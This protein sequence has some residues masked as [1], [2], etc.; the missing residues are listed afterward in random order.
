[1]LSTTS[2]QARDALAQH[3]FTNL[4]GH[5]ASLQPGQIQEILLHETVVSWIRVRLAQG[6]RKECW[7][8][9]PA[10]YEARLKQA[11]ADINQHL[12]VAGL[13]NNLPKRMTQ[14]IAA[15]GGRI[16]K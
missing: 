11:A 8:E 14:V 1:M 6:T 16:R 2:Q 10:Q 4:M 9:A 12:D 7:L 3:G 15:K 5:D 13:C